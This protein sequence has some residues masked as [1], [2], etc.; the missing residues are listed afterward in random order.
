MTCMDRSYTERVCNKEG[1]WVRLSKKV[2]RIQL[3]VLVQ[4]NYG[5]QYLVFILKILE[6]QCPSKTLLRYLFL[7]VKGETLKQSRLLFVGLKFW[8]TFSN[9][10]SLNKKIILSLICFIEG[11]K[12]H[13]WWDFIILCNFEESIILTNNYL[14]SNYW[15]NQDYFYFPQ[16]IHRDFQWTLVKLQ[17][18]TKR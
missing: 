8:M 2:L 17:T 4:W 12:K 13:F 10:E 1:N 6:S 18:K 9:C 14:H 11:H 5:F 16:K 3:C 15:N 7:I